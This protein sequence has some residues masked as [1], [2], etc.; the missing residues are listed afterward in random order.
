VFL[1]RFLRE[2][3]EGER[4]YGAFEMWSGYTPGAARTTPASEFVV[5]NPDHAR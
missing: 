1:K 2:P 5:F 3:V 4:R